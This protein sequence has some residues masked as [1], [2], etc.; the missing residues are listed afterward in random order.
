MLV[1][2]AGSRLVLVLEVGSRLVEVVGVV[3]GSRL[4]EEGEDRAVRTS[5]FNLL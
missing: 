1:Q 5:Y 4:G 2:E 3:V